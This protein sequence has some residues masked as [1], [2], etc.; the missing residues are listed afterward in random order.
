MAKNKA[1]PA[2]QVTPTPKKTDATNNKKATISAKKDTKALGRKTNAGPLTREEHIEATLGSKIFNFKL[3]ISDY[4]NP[5]NITGQDAD[6]HVINLIPQ[7][8]TYEDAWAA[9]GFKEEFEKKCEE[10]IRLIRLQRQCPPAF[11]N[12]KRRKDDLERMKSELDTGFKGKDDYNWMDSDVVR[13]SLDE[14][15]N[16][17]R[18]MWRRKH[19][20]LYGKLRPKVEA[21][22]TVMALR[23]DYYILRLKE[24]DIRY[25]WATN[26][27]GIP[28][29]V[30]LKE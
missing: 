27:D 13:E 1:A 23:P 28:G 6:P 14:E 24:G 12:E 8:K 7:I 30:Q 20:I 21:E 17:A 19:N 25:D 3:K 18:K 16:Y 29:I 15:G 11:S 9:A 2:Q 5:N 4:G 10:Q 22:I 26:K